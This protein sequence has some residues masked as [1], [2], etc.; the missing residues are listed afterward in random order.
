MFQSLISFAQTWVLMPAC[1]S[2]PEGGIYQCPYCME[3]FR[4]PNSLRAHMRFKCSQRRPSPS[5]EGSVA[6]KLAQEHQERLLAAYR[7]P[8][9]MHPGR[10]NAAFYP[11]PGMLA[12]QVP[13][14][15]EAS[16]M[17]LPSSASSTSSGLSPSTAVS[18]ADRGTRITPEKR[19]LEDDAG[20]SPPAKRLSLEASPVSPRSSP[21]SSPHA[22]SS[23]SPA[24]P[25]QHRT[26]LDQNQNVHDVKEEEETVSAFRKVEKQI[27]RH[28]PPLVS[29]SGSTDKPYDTNLPPG[30]PAN[31]FTSRALTEATDSLKSLPP[32][33]HP[34]S[35]IPPY[36]MIPRSV[37]PPPLVPPTNYSENVPLNIA[38]IYRNNLK[39]NDMPRLSDKLTEIRNLENNNIAMKLPFMGRGG[40]TPLPMQYYKSNNPMVDKLLNSNLP[41]MPTAITQLNLLQNWCAKCNA[42]FRMTSDL[43]Y[44]MRSHHHLPKDPVKAKRE[45]KLK[46]TICGET[47]RERH[48]L[49]RH[50][51]SHT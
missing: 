40:M 4:Y 34:S 17:A 49:T 27:R 19:S 10:G 21:R 31:I 35:F 5:M 47:F 12:G 51:T 2:F 28:S 46:C 44:H 48:H 8:Y 14:F 33:A 42:T 39:M 1:S 7:F 41:V 13:S 11:Y 18:T 24:S 29:H 9:M 20:S 36:P 50:M 6:P 26:T 30:H 25:V 45:E 22:T 16:L 23:A 38:D 43:V 15:T 37:I 32:G 3:N